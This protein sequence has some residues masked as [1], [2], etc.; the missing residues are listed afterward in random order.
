MCRQVSVTLLHMCKGFSHLNEEADDHD[1]IRWHYC[2]SAYVNEGVYIRKCT[3]ALGVVGCWFI[4]FS[5]RFF[6]W[7]VL[8][9]PQTLCLGYLSD[10]QGVGLLTYRKVFFICLTVCAQGYPEHLELVCYSC[11]YV[12]Q[13]ACHPASIWL[14]TRKARTT[15]LWS[16]VAHTG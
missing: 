9:K 10:S 16:E 7:F 14:S 6:L 1:I 8:R 13:V 5:F 3:Q 12:N 11:L 2:C 15:A 4:W